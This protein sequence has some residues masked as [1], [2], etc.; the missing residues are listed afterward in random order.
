MKT[1]QMDPKDKRQVN[2]DFTLWLGTSNISSVAWDVP[3]GLTT[4]DTGNTTKIATNYF[5]STD[6]TVEN[7]YEVACEITTSDTVAREKTQRFLLL[8]EKNC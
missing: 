1:L 3:A 4:S 6:D 7:E 5:S 8:V 2:I